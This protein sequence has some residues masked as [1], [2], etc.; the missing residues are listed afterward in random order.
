MLDFTA[1]SVAGHKYQF[2]L[3]NAKISNLVLSDGG[4]STDVAL[5]CTIS[6]EYDATSGAAMT[7]TRL[8]P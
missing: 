1:G 4:N 6:A 3:P 2:V 7:I 8:V 5:S